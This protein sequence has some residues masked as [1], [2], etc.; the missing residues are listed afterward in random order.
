MR[1]ATSGFPE[2][3]SEPDGAVFGRP[4]S[5]DYDV[6][7]IGAR[8]AGA[9]T[10][11]LLARRGHR[12]LMVDRAPAGADT[13]ST[14]AVLRSGVLQLKRWGLLDRVI[15]SGT[16]AIPRVT[17]GFGS[18]LVPIDLSNDF[19]VDS[20]YAPRRT[21]LDPI[22]V[23][24]AV[25]AG[26]EYLDRCRAKSLVKDSDGTVRGVVLDAGDGEVTVPARMVIGAD[27]AWSKMA[28]W[29]NAPTYSQYPA[30][31]T[32]YYA[33][34]RGIETHGVYFQ[35]TPGVTAGL[36]PTNDDLVC[37]YGGWPK[38][39]TTAFRDEPDAAFT[40]VV[41]SA[42][43]LLED[44]MAGGTRVSPFRGIQGLA[45]FLRK[46]GGPGWALVGDAAYT[47][48]PVS[49]HGISDAL[50]DA[51]LCACAVDVSLTDPGAAEAAFDRYQK[52]RDELSSGMLAWSSELAAYQWDEARA[53][54]LMRNLSG[55]V[56]A[57]SEA[58]VSGVGM[59]L[60]AV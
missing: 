25:E 26:V 36:I 10:A 53:S 54:Q 2:T 57:E 4:R 56:K 12:V 6:V 33:Y 52:V 3:G 28:K 20:L 45:G 16:P 22:L 51:E 59:P 39:T 49:A 38:E 55:A 41:G 1:R 14:H 37:V 19:G 44:A 11:M 13:T 58:L 30:T 40:S 60:S 50:R 24:A 17:L 5:V 47:K 27:G 32:V 46:P 9:A 18:E 21:V 7:V 34:Y 43:P 48:D 23:G 29:V 42:H 15:D 8:V 35:F 31:N